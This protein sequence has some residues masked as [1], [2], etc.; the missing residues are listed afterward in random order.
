MSRE[1]K[2]KKD[3]FVLRIY[4]LRES[5]LAGWLKYKPDSNGLRIDG[6]VKKET[7]LLSDIFKK[8]VREGKELS[9]SCQ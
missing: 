2:I 5:H 1:L 8:C 7:H 6:V 3:E 9:M 4:S